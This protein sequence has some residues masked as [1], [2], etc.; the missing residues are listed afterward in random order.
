MWNVYS[1][2]CRILKTESSVKT[3]LKSENLYLKDYINHTFSTFQKKFFNFPT[4]VI[5]IFLKILFE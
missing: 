3:E 2:T 1:K 5:N 4:F